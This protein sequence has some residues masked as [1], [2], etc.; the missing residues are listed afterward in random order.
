MAPI[1]QGRPRPRK[2]FTELLPVTLPTELSALA[3][4]C[5]ATF[6]AKVSG[7]LVPRA[8]SVMAVISSGMP[9]QQP[10]RAARSLTS[11]VTRPIMPRAKMKQS[12]P[13]QRPGGGMIAKRSFQTSETAWTHHSAGP[14]FACSSKLPLQQTAAANCSHHCPRCSARRSRFTQRRAR[15]ASQDGW[16]SATM[17][18]SQTALLSSLSV[19]LSNFT[20]GLASLSATWK[21]S[22]LSMSCRE[23]LRMRISTVLV[24]SPCP[25][26]MVPSECM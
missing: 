23:L 17:T 8:T 16:P 15:R 22:L 19:A 24:T 6:E 21:L 26:V 2:T 14:A 5:A 11:A 18:T 12:Q 4:C 1:I 25:K 10:R 13:P 3:S 20:P 9:M 7:K